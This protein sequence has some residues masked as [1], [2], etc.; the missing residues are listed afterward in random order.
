[1]NRITLILLALLLL[2]GCTYQIVEVRQY[3][4]DVYADDNSTVT[5]TIPISPSVSR[6]QSWP[7]TVSTDATLTGIP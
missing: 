6:T 2:A 1:V 4:L 7:S 5:L 3:R